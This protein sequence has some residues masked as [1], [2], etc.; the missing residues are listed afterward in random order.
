MG[1]LSGL[2]GNV[3]EVDTDKLEKEFKD[4]IFEGEQITQAFKLIRD[5]VV[6]TSKRLILVD[7]Q[8]MTGKKVEYRTIPY[9]SI[10]QFAVETSGHF[11]LDSE[12]KIW[13]SGIHDPIKK[14]FKKGS[15]IRAIQNVLAQ[16][17]LG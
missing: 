3:S 16:H 14:Q 11:D 8:G 7:K 12:L 2:M 17:M 4:I 1:I 5:L 6:F 9:K 15:N 10:I 13:L